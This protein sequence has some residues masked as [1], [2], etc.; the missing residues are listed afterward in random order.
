[1]LICLDWPCYL[2]FCL[3]YFQSIPSDM[4]F[5]PNS[6]PPCYKT[7]DEVQFFKIITISVQHSA[8]I[9]LNVNNV[10]QSSFLQIC[11]I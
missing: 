9:K 5:D 2:T 6:N 1:M 10:K 4:E 11:I 7:Q 3:Y 8:F